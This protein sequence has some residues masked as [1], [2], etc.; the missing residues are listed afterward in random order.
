MAFSR[1]VVVVEVAAPLDEAVAPTVIVVLL[2]AEI[3]LVTGSIEYARQGRDVGVG[4]FTGESPGADS[5][6][7]FSGGQRRPRRYAQG[8]VAVVGVEGNAFCCERV[9]VRCLYD[10]VAIGAGD[11]IVVLVGHDPEDVRFFHCLLLRG[12]C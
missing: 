12:E 10:L 1:L 7:I 8:R 6:A 2:A 5:R 9:H 4:Q 11:R 3:T